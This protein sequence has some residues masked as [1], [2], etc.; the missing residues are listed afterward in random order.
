MS[1]SVVVHLS[2]NEDLPEAIIFQDPEIEQLARVLFRVA[3]AHGWARESGEFAA[4][5]PPPS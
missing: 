2:H 1:H 4:A 3:L 5:P